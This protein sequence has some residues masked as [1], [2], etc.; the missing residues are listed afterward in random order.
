VVKSE[1]LFDALSP[2]FAGSGLE[3][4]DVHVTSSSV[5]VTV[6]RQ[7][8]VDLDSLAEANRTVSRILDEIDPL[9][10]RYTLEVSSPGLERPL[11]RPEDFSR[12]LGKTVTLRTL[13]GSGEVRRVTGRLSACDETGFVLEATGLPDDP[14]RFPF[15]QVERARTVFE[16]GSKSKPGEKARS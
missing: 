9:P 4:V 10:G 16:W 14:V 7:G 12:A 6:D 8:G 3:L 2:A 5:Q 11:R 15:D 13:P 1:G